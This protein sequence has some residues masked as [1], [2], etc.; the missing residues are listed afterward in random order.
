MFFILAAITVPYKALGDTGEFPTTYDV[1]NHCTVP[2]EI[3]LVSTT[4][5]HPVNMDKERNNED[6]IKIFFI[7][8]NTKYK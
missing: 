2:V 1:V 3:I 8:K 7:I 6:I 5:P 4:F